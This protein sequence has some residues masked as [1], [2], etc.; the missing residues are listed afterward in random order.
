MSILMLTSLDK[1]Q[2]TLCSKLLSLDD[3]K[4]QEG[5]GPT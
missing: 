4:L 3:A 1:D 2:T 5:L